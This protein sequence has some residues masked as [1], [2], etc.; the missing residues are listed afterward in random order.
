MSNSNTNT[1]IALKSAFLRAQIRILSQPLQVP[2]RWLNDNS[3][4]PLGMVE[5]VLRHVNR[6]LRQHVKA[7]YSSLAIRHVAEQIDKL[8]WNAA[9]PAGDEEQG[10][11]DVPR[12][13]ADLTHDDTI[14]LLPDDW[15]EEADTT[16]FNRRDTQLELFAERSSYTHTLSELRSLS[17]RRA[18]LRSRIKQLRDL[19]RALE[20]FRNPQRDVQPNL[21]T[22]DGELEKELAKMRTLSARVAE[23]LEE[24]SGKQRLGYED[25]GNRGGL[26]QWEEPGWSGTEEKMQRILG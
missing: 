16:T 21:V 6:I 9:E 23:K 8:Y 4:L 18:A 20:P 14:S 17:E 5:D 12:R 13:D 25:P 19:N 3:E 15:P 24:D 7:T 11:S 26:E 2:E 10:S 22:S 1:V